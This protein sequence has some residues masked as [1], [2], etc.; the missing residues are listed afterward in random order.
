MQA[1]AKGK[2]LKRPAVRELALPASVVGLLNRHQVCQALGGICVRKLTQM[3][4]S[5]HFPRNDKRLGKSPRWS[6]A[7]VNRWVEQL[8]DDAGARGGLADGLGPSE[9]E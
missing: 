9:E 8:P 7:L 5:G 3:V 4:S 6:V 2:E 1:K